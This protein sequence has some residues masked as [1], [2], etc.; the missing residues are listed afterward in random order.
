[1]AEYD[2]KKFIIASI[3]IKTVSLLVSLYLFIKR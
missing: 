3:F 1:M 2:T